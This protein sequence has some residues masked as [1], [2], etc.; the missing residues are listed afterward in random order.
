MERKLTLGPE[1]E[2]RRLL[3]LIYREV[4]DRQVVD[5]M[6]RVPREAF[7]PAASRHLAY[8]DIPLPIGEGQTVSQPLMWP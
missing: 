3:G 8:E 5:A 1:K 4:E 6:A 2:K 7:V